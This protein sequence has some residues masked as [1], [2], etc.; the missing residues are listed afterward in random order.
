MLVL[1][2]LISAK[3]HSPQ[4]LNCIQTLSWFYCRFGAIC[5]TDYPVLRWLTSA[6]IPGSAWQ[7]NYHLYC[8][9]A[10][11]RMTE[12][13]RFPAGQLTASEWVVLL[14]CRTV[15]HGGPGGQCALWA[16][17][18]ARTHTLTI[19]Y[20]V[21]NAPPPPPPP[22]L[23]MRRRR[24]SWQRSKM[25]LTGSSA[26]RHLLTRRLQSALAAAASRIGSY[27][28]YITHSRTQL[29]PRTERHLVWVSV[30][31]LYDRNK[32]RIATIDII[33]RKPN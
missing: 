31:N 26:V 13:L 12:I 16:V 29:E 22:A 18:A 30:R 28:R 25:G 15:G 24:F 33:L 1:E 2:W 5:V 7:A 8:I 23:T 6:G 32:R 11:R 19:D 9:E 27:T 14:T 21:L 20:A 10:P 4:R 3:Y 17:V